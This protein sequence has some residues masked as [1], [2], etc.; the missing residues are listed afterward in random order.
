MV[1]YKD[2]LW[3]CPSCH[4]GATI[5]ST[6]RHHGVTTQRLA[7]SSYEG[8]ATVSVF[9]TCPNS[10]CQRFSFYVTCFD[11]MVWK[12]TSG[13]GSRKYTVPS[14]ANLVGSWRLIPALEEAKEFP[15]C[16]PEPIR[17][18]YT[19]AHL[20]RN[21]SP[22]ASATLARR[23]LQGMIRDFHNVRKHNLKAE[24]EAIED[25][26]APLTWQAIDAVRSVGNIG[27]HM[28]KDINVIVEVD[29]GEAAMLI[30]LIE[31]LVE[32]WYVNQ[33]EREQNLENIVQ[34]G[35]AKERA[36]KPRPAE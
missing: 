26:V 9:I 29:P 14:D 20:I 24:I 11:K 18:D 10:K 2:F 32:D 12:S 35:E 13:V 21:L 36:R 25:K 31:M 4:K 1:P 27:A 16:V 34:M 7:G 22:K 19:E 6:N 30:G 33:H 8:P 15:Y 23:C 17:Q 3:E 28:E 5:T